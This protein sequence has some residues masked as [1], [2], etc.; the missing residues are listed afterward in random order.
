[1][2][3][4]TYS[5][6]DLV[7]EVSSAIQDVDE[8]VLS[9]DY[10]RHEVIGLKRGPGGVTSY[11]GFKPFGFEPVSFDYSDPEAHFANFDAIR[12][13]EKYFAF[14]LREWNLDEHGE[15]MGNS[16]LNFVI[17]RL[18]ASATQLDHYG[19]LLVAEYAGVR[20]AP[21]RRVQGINKRQ[22]LLNGFL[23]SAEVALEVYYKKRTCVDVLPTLRQ[24]RPVTKSN[25]TEPASESE[26]I[27]SS[28]SELEVEES[29]RSRKLLRTLFSGFISDS[30]LITCVTLFTLASAILSAYG[31]SVAIQTPKDASWDSPEFYNTAQNALMQLLG[32]YV[33]IVPALRHKNLQSS[34]H[35]WSWVLAG[36][37]F[38][39]PFVA[40][41]YFL[42][43]PD[44]SQLV[45]FVGSA[46]QSTIILQLIWAVDDMEKKRK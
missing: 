25:T 8:Q 46:I 36:L 24:R 32:L 19:P 15:R 20:N 16:E 11:S 26:E 21:T 43:G 5:L 14:V 17:E 39:A 7:R 45:L 29:R 33:T 28:N 42:H 37:S 30:T 44:A 1:M 34:Y 18:S 27:Q 41:G 3:Q 6:G 10:I 40:I 38:I 2:T 35:R 31:F 22:T 4:P 9:S 13:W 23:Y 12:L